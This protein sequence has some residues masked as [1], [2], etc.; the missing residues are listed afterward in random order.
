MATRSAKTL[1]IIAFLTI[2]LFILMV[3]GLLL[4]IGS[5]RLRDTAQHADAPTPTLLH[6]T[7]TPLHETPTPTPHEEP[8]LNLYNWTTYMD[9]AILDAFE[10][11]YG[12]TVVEDFFGDNE[13]LYAKIQ[14]GN[15]GYDVIV[16][17]DYMVE[18]MVSEGL[19]AELDHSKVPNISNVDSSFADPVYDPRL[20]HCVPYQWGTIALAYNFEAVGKELDSWDVMFSGESAGRI[21][22]LAGSSHESRAVLGVTLL[23]LGYD[24]NTT[25]PEEI[26][27]ARDLLIATKDDVVGY[28]PDTGQE[29][30][31][32]GD[33]D[34]VFEYGPDIFLIAQEGWGGTFR[35]VIPREGAIVWADN[36][37]IPTGA[38]HPEL[39]HKFIDFILRPEIGAQLS[40]YIGYSTPNAASLPLIDEALREFPGLYPT[41]E[42]KARLH[43]IRALGEAEALYDAAWNE[44]GVE[45]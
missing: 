21:A 44:L 20:A 17:T 40:N 42:E 12:V 15:P 45:P 30:L 11:E 8:V 23:Y 3:V 24:P 6:D 9:P 7:P 39:A 18:I 29:S 37:C 32:A 19:L 25:N 14:A 10:E 2:G 41:E 27:E 38:P 28:L 26:N 22:W 34:I 43:F 13:E 31:L 36:L 4:A 1:N 33:V 35:Y 5:S 16:P